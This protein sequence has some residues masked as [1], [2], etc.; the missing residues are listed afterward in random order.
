MSRQH[1]CAWVY[2]LVWCTGTFI[3]VG[4]EVAVFLGVRSDLAVVLVDEDAHLGQKLHLLL[5]QVVCGNLGHSGC[6]LQVSDFTAGGQQF[7]IRRYEIRTMFTFKC[8]K[9]FG[10]VIFFLVFFSRWRK[11]D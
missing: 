8:L 2:I 5:I 10:M 1:L 9:C 4:V 7:M 3:D 6:R 11:D